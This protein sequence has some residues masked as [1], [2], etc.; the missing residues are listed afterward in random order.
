MG[1]SDKEFVGE[2]AGGGYE[3]ICRSACD[4]GFVAHGV[5]LRR[6]ISLARRG[7]VAGKRRDLIERLGE[8]QLQLQEMTRDRDCYR[9][10]NVDI[11]NER[12]KLKDKLALETANKE[13]HYRAWQNTLKACEG[14]ET[15]KKPKYDCRLT[16]CCGRTL[17]NVSPELCGV[18]QYLRRL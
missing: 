1:L 9:D 12:D 17:G 8:R 15:D 3:I 11:N 14:L 13:S 2:I 6:L 10:Y 16:K 18:C 7:C 5:A 4:I